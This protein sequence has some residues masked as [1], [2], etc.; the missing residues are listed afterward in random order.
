MI[1]TLSIVNILRTLTIRN[2]NLIKVLSIL[3]LLLS[4]F[5]VAEQVVKEGFITL[6]VPHDQC[7][8][9]CSH[10]SLS[11]ANKQIKTIEIKE[12]KSVTISGLENGNY[13]ANFFQKNSEIKKTAITFTVKHHAMRFALTLFILGGILFSALTISLYK[14]LKKTNKHDYTSN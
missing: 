9:L 11:T 12:L 4:Q 6:N 3:F 1:C 14:F 2:I 7:V 13:Q 10:M 5:A 8:D